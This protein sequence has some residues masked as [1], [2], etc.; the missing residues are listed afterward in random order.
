[1]NPPAPGAAPRWAWVVATGLGSG[2]MRPAPGTWGSLVALL[3]WVAARQWGSPH[4][5]SGLQAWLLGA[6]APALLITLVGVPASDRVARASGREDPGFIVIDEWAGQWIALL[7]LPFVA[8]GWLDPWP[9]LPFLLFRLFD[10]WKPGPVDAAQ[11]LPGGWG[12]VMDDVLAGILAA[13]LT[14]AA[15][16]LVR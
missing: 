6:L 14:G 9:V 12:I 8:Q 1:M 16:I 5:G 2:R 3:V 13:L 4:L 15:W 7:G 11:R 10:I